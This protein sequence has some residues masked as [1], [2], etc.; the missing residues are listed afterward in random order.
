MAKTERP[1][2]LAILLC[3]LLASVVRAQ[4]PAASSRTEWFT[5]YTRGMEEARKQERPALIVFGA[6]WCGW[7]SLMERDVLTDSRVVKLVADFVPIHVDVEKDPK[8]AFL[9][10]VSA[11]PRIVVLNKYGEI[12]ADRTGYMDAA[13][14]YDVL[15]EARENAFKHFEGALVV[16]VPVAIK[17]LETF[18]RDFERLQETI[19]ADQLMPYLMDTDPD[20]RERA[21]TLLARMGARANPSLVTALASPCL[22]LRIAAEELLR[23]QPLNVGAFDPWAPRAEREAAYRPWRAWL[24]RELARGVPAGR[25]DS[26]AAQMLATAPQAW[27][28]RKAGEAAVSWSLPGGEPCSATMAVPQ[29]AGVADSLEVRCALAARLCLVLTVADAGGTA[30]EGGRRI[31]HAPQPPFPLLDTATN[32]PPQPQPE[33]P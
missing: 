27:A 2:T 8:T 25:I 22:S 29:E 11:L 7:C 28:G 13:Q 10:S 16:E 33:S 14:L 18:E 20:I 19:H 17:E 1:A 12:I 15:K 5:S 24:S 6:A 26:L 4:D 32:A 30:R 21:A 31:E 23:K 3:A 9:Y